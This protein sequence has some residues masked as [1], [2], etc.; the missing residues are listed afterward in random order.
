[1]PPAARKKP[2]NSKRP[3]AEGWR[4]SPDWQIIAR[5]AFEMGY[6]DA[7]DY[8]SSAE[9]FDEIKR[10]WNP[11]TGYDIGGASHDRLRQM[12]LQWPVA[13]SVSSACL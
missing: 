8:E 12:L 4:A 7:F 6:G 10:A 2:R 5:V 3:D 9:I 11:K 13:D 1:M